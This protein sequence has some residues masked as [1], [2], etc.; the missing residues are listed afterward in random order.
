MADTHSDVLVGAYPGIDA[1]TKDFDALAEL[2]ERPR[3]SQWRRRS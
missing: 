3:R 1:A 2:V